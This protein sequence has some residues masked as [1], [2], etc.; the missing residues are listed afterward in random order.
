VELSCGVAHSD[1]LLEMSN[2][3]RP[4]LRVGRA[5]NTVA[6]PILYPQWWQLLLAACGCQPPAASSAVPQHACPTLANPARLTPPSTALQCQKCHAWL[7][8]SCTNYGCTPCA[9]CDNKG[10]VDCPPG[11]YLDVIDLPT[12]PKAK[13]NA[14]S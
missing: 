8:S 5:G 13:L 6:E 7:G 3:R 12:K 10:C 4:G 11:N 2:T 14:V 1:F 9:T